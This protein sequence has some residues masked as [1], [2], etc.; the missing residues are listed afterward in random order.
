VKGSEQPEQTRR[1]FVTY[2]IAPSFWC[3]SCVVC[4]TRDFPDL[5]YG[6]LV[7]LSDLGIGLVPFLSTLLGF[8]MVP[9]LNQR[10]VAYG[11]NLFA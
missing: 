9:P 6:Q 7:A 3:A 4:E 5:Q 1:L 2:R 11:K 8:G 10:G